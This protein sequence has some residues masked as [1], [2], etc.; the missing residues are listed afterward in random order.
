M[1]AWPKRHGRSRRRLASDAS[2]PGLNT[3]VLLHHAFGIHR[4]L[5]QRVVRPLAAALAG[6]RERGMEI[7]GREKS[8]TLVAT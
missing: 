5:V 2:V 8:W 1:A 4:N 3:D 7:D 6:G